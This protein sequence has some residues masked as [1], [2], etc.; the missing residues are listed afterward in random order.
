MR[1]RSLPQTLGNM[2]DASKRS[3]YKHCGSEV[4]VARGF[5]ASPRTSAMLSQQNTPFPH[6]STFLETGMKMW[7]STSFSLIEFS[8]LPMEYTWMF[9]VGRCNMSTKRIIYLFRCSGRTAPRINN[10]VVLAD[11][12]KIQS[13]HCNVHIHLYKTQTVFKALRSSILIEATLKL[14]ISKRK[15][16]YQIIKVF[17]ISQQI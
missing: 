14:H 13:L 5:R 12:L 6:H 2:S 1:G 4:R 15:V 8:H 9:T 10:L 16:I 7:K 17:V 3:S 11:S